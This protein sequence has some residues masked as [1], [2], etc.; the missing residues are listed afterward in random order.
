MSARGVPVN[1]GA[2]LA[3]G[4]PVNAGA[5]LACGVP[6][7]AGA[8]LACGTLRPALQNFDHLI[9]PLL[10]VIGWAFYYNLCRREAKKWMIDM[11]DE[12]RFE[13]ID[14]IAAVNAVNA[15]LRRI[16]ERLIDHGER[17][18]YIA[19]RLCELGGLELDIKTLFLLSIFHDIG[20]Y[21]TDEIDRMV[22]FETRE[23]W[24]HAIYGGLFLK[25]LTPLSSHADA[26]VY[27]HCPWSVLEKLAPCCRDY[28]A[29][30]HLAD[31]IDIVLAAT[32]D[33]RRAEE[34]VCALDGVFRPEYVAVMRRCFREDGGIGRGLRDG[35]Y[36]AV[37]MERCAAFRL[38]VRETLEYLKML[39]YSIDFRSEYT[40]THTINTV[41]LSMYIAARF[42]LGEEELEKL[43]LGALLHDV[44]KIAIPVS[45]VENPGKLSDEEMRVMRTHV[46]ETDELIRGIVPEDIRRIAARH[47]ESWTAPVT[48]WVLPAGS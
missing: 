28:A 8:L 9:I 12:L 10:R 22:E 43:Y 7:N 11:Y 44:G 3:C 24:S 18:A 34:L 13:R 17:V 41:S 37:N 27:H 23:V 21:K 35:S 36:R 16:D 2:L 5:L 47:H 46:R 6:V 20:A 45:I 39:V 15:T 48:P 42:A 40:V 4:V 30:I 31:R 25:Y 19:C 38:P 32:G 14:A 29:M 33:E 1:A 26:I